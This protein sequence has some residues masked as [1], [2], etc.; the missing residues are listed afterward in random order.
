M[1]TTSFKNH[2]INKILNKRQIS[3][4]EEKYWIMK[5]FLNQFI[6]NHYLIIKKL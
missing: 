6:Q 3:I 1:E 5:I 4:Y 2:I